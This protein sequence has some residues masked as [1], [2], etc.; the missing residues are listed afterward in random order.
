MKIKLKV[1]HL[2]YFFV[3]L[4]IFIPFLVMIVF[5]QINLYLAEKKLEDGD[6]AGK[7]QLLKVLETA[8]FDWQKWN[9]IEEHMLQGGMA[10]RFDIYVGPSMIQ[11]GQS[12]ESII[13]FSWEEK[14]PFL[15]D[16]LESGPTN[17]YLVTVA[18]DLAS[19]YQ[20]EGKLDKA[21]EALMTAVE[22]FST[23][24]YSFH[25]N[26]L[27]LERIKLAVRH[28]QFEKAE[29]YSNELT[30]K[31]NADDYYMTAEIAKLRAEMIIKQGNLQEAYAEIKDA[32]TGF[33][34]NWKNQ[35]ERLAEDGLPIEEMEDIE[36]SV[37]YN[38]LQSLE[39]HLTRAMDEQRDAIVTVKGKIVRQD[40]TPV[41]NAGVFLREEQNVNRSVGDDEAYQ[42]TT[43]ETGAYKIEGVIPGSY[44]L[45]AGFLYDQIDG[46]TW[47]LDTNEWINI[48]GSE[49]VNYDI[50]L[51]PLIEI[52]SPV[53]QTVITGDTMHFSWEEVEEA[54]YYQLNLGLEFESGG[55]SST[56][57]QKK[58]MDTEIDIPV[59][60]LY[61]RQ[62]GVSF[63]GE[64]DVDPYALLAFTNPKNRFSWSVDAYNSNGDLITRSNGYRLGE[65]TIGN[66][67]FF[68]LKERE[69]TEADQ[70]L[71]DHQPKE[72]LEAYQEN[73]EDNPNDIHSLRMISRLIG[74]KG[75]GLRETRDELALPYLIELAEKTS[76]PSYSYSVAI[77]YYEKREWEAFHK[78]FDRYVRL[79]DGEITEYIHGI[80]ANAFMFQGEYE[81]AK[82]QL[83]I[84]VNRDSTNRFVGNWIAVELYLGES[85]DQVIQ[86][87]QD[88]P[89]RDYGTEHMDWVDIIQELK[90][91]SEQ[92]SAYENE[93]KRTLSMY[94]EG[95]EAELKEWKEETNLAGLQRFIK[96]LE[97][98]N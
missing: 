92:Y 35:R 82:E 18:T 85:F 3:G 34:T 6:P 58:I 33:E 26:E 41:E 21:D 13:G 52:E 94:F 43:D 87:A 8:S 9:V 25:Q 90:E 47:P 67:P 32:L 27:L 81:E 86:I 36:S 89:E 79:N 56:S 62:V 88:H 75:D 5:P 23:T 17:G 91:E 80:Y 97:N 51:H 16:Y 95:K 24:Q 28:S 31:L 37:V 50:T 96:E 44:Q 66:L 59:E 71:L 78:W 93:L 83:E 38:Q 11:G 20:Q 49:D 70:L 69:L 74:I 40:G 53:N 63:D 57:F 98:V 72:A 55:T 29:K 77:Y 46:W 76:T 39:R 54:A 1:K 60:K 15:T 7:H 4:L 45:F 48:D 73:Y 10:N 68:Y 12:S 64:G 2:V 61:D 19:H 22:R 14:L 42:V 84:A 65:D 30:E